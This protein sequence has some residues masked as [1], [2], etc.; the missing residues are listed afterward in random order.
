M[1]NLDN[2]VN[3]NNEKQNEKWPYIP[4]HPYRILITGRS[5]SGKT[6]TL[7]HLINEQKT[8][9]RFICMQKI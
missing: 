9:T 4:D 1:I 7:L 8:L 3:N 5:E 2:I 6:K